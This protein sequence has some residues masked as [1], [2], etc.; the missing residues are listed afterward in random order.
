VHR[1]VSVIRGHDTPSDSASGRYVLLLLPYPVQSGHPISVVHQVRGIIAESSS[2]GSLNARSLALT[3]ADREFR[4]SASHLGSQLR[5]V[6]SFSDAIPFANAPSSILNFIYAHSSCASTHGRRNPTYPA[7]L[8]PNDAATLWR[9]NFNVKHPTVVYIHGYS[10][11]ALGKGPI[12]IRN[13]TFPPNA[14]PG[15]ALRSST[16]FLEG[17]KSILSSFSMHGESS[18]RKFNRQPFPPKRIPCYFA[19]VGANDRCARA[20]PA[21]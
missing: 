3:L 6:S 9:S 2:H 21:S 17:K 4:L 13:G 7:I 18:M 8:N 5:Q 14:A 19:K 1:S 10:D 12:A 20:S 11:S 16:R 15:I